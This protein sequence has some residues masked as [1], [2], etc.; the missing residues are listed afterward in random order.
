MKFFFTSLH[1][2]SNTKILKQSNVL[3]LLRYLTALDHKP[4]NSATYIPDFLASSDK[5]LQYSS[6]CRSQS[7]PAQSSVN[8]SPSLLASVA[9]VSQNI[10]STNS[11][12]TAFVK[13]TA[14]MYTSAVPNKNFKISYFKS[15]HRPY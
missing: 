13:Q 1:V 11:P 9:T 4:T 15:L 7:D 3:L 10:T 2:K 14:Q 6:W 12:S 8:P 5:T